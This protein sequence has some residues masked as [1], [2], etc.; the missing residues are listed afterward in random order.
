MLRRTP[1]ILIATV[2]VGLCAVA[3]GQS[4]AGAEDDDPYPQASLQSVTEPASDAVSLLTTSTMTDALFTNMEQATKECVER[5]GFEYQRASTP[6]RK[7]H[8]EEPNSETGYGIADKLRPEPDAAGRSRTAAREANVAY[9]ERL[10]ADRRSTYL[11]IIGA[12]SP[13]GSAAPGKPESCPAAVAEAIAQPAMQAH[14]ELSPQVRAL[15][16]AVSGDAVVR[17]ADR[18]WSACMKSFGFIY[19][20]PSAPSQQLA[21]ELTEE[22]AVPVDM[23]SFR[24][25]ERKIAGADSTCRE[26][27]GH[28]AAANEAIARQSEKFPLSPNLVHRA[29]GAIRDEEA[30]K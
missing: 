15:I 21:A 17:K 10:P 25:R 11:R 24:K 2:G 3:A 29:A 1:R 8:S 13:K 6:A 5:A 12:T 23:A 28:N 27:S 16:K 18:E 14:H 26:Q 22:H 30:S 20:T 7:N 4:P 9:A 19:A